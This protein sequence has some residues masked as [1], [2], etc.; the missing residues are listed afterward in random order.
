MK[1]VYIIHVGL[2]GLPGEKTRCIH[3]Q[4]LCYHSPVEILLRAFSLACFTTTISMVVPVPQI[5]CPRENF[6]HI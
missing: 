4:Y 2:Q 1:I 5:H 6:N 3:R